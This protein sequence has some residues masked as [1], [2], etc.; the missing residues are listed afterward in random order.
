MT[1]LVALLLVFSLDGSACSSPPPAPPPQPAPAPAPPPAP[2]PA[3]D[4]YDEACVNERSLG[5]SVSDDCAAVFRHAVEPHPGQ[6]PLTV[7]SEKTAQCI[8]AAT[9]KE[10]VRA[11]GYADCP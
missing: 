10:A 1:R 5:C 8:A 2:V 4:V 6:T 7:V 11:C 9:S 3:S